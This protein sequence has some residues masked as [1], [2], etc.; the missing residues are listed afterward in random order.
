MR[1]SFN[2]ALSLAMFGL[3]LPTQLAAQTVQTNEYIYIGIEAEDHISKNERWVTTTPTTPMIE[4]DPDGNHSD[5]ASGQTYLELLPDI[6]VTHDDP[7]SPPIAFWPAGGQ[8]PDADYAVNFPEPGRYYVHV[9]AYSTGTEDN[10]IH[11]GFNGQWPDSGQR[12]QFCS[13]AKR[14]WW[15]SSAQRDSGGMGAC[16]IEKS[17][18][19]DVPSAG[20]HTVSISARED[21][22]EIDRLVL[23][24]DKSGNTRVCTPVNIDDVNCRNGSI[25]SADEFV[26]VRVRVITLPEGAD[27]DAD[28][29]D[30][31]E[32]D[33]GDNITLTARI[34]NL[35]NFDT[36][37]DI[38]L[39]LSPVPGEWNMLAMDDRCEQVGTEFECLLD[40]L[41]P[42][43]PDEFAPFVFTM[44]A[45]ESGDLRIDAAVT[46]SDVDDTPANDVHAGLV[47][48]I[49]G[50][51]PEPLTTDVRLN[52]DT[53]KNRYETGETIGLSVF[54]ANEGNNVA[55]DVTF[56]IN[57]PAGLSVNAAALPS[58]CIAGAQLLCSFASINPADSE[59]FSVELTGESEGVFTLNGILEASNDDNASNNI[60][61]DSV[62][63]EAPVDAGT[64]SGTS[65]TS[66]TAGSATDGDDTATDGATAGSTTDG[67]DTATDGSATTSGSTTFSATAG[68]TSGTSTTSGTDDSTS[69]TTG[70]GGTSSSN[71][72]A[73]SHWFALLILLVLSA[74]CYGWHQGQRIAV[75]K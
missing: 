19:I 66:G 75:R 41:H 74:R 21:G 30:P 14:S 37:N 18:W 52:M 59:S 62:L 70:T 20:Q 47:R 34:E 50:T 46:S 5:Q 31:V 13:A 2:L 53:D 36:A 69:G 42:T 72:G 51:A 17:I 26:D 58:A 3:F 61:A 33:Q 45:V 64:T 32:I 9:R 24:K 38:V 39:T 4:D 49:P 7:F 6:R 8:G 55:E 10:G 48:V 27:P 29:P 16:G 71:S 68:S 67:D 43:A 65:T 23:L 54:I 44:Q 40:S 11:I 22:F 15:W 60:D 57:V 28:Q 56:R 25:E 73:A 12:M 63:V 35:D 1:V